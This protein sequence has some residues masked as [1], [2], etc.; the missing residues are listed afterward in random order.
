MGTPPDPLERPP[1]ADNIIVEL[2]IPL[3]EQNPP[4]LPDIPEPPEP[5]PG[6]PGGEATVAT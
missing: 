4:D 5:E 6:D 2:P 3:S 1:G